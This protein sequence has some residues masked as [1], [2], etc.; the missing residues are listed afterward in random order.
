MRAP[1]FWLQS[2]K[3]TAAKLLSPVGTAYG[4]ITARY[5]RRHAPHAG[6]PLVCVGNFVAGGA[7]KTPTA[8]TL[9]KFLIERGEHPI[10]LSRG[11]GGS[12]PATPLLVDPQEHAADEVGDEPLL[13]A[14][15]APTIVT[16]DRPAGAHMAIRRGAT[17]QPVEIQL[18]CWLARN[19]SYQRI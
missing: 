7:G 15:V 8:I 14:R 11:Y 12:R 16:G 4:A 18:G 19:L 1:P 9:A 3:A 13:L 6:V 10:F 5:M 2:E 17:G